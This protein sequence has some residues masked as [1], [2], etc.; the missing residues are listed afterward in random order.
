MRRELD[1]RTHRNGM[2]KDRARA[3][4]R[5]LLAGLVAV[6]M[7][8]MAYAH[9]SVWPR[10]SNAGATERYTVR[11]PTEGKVATT[12]VSLEVPE[13]VRVEELLTPMGWTYEVKREDDRVVA[14]TWNVNV[15]P[16]EF[17]EVGFVALNPRDKS[18][19]VWK[20]RQNFAD[21]SSSDWTNGPNGIYRTAVTSLTPAPAR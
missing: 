3:T 11:V 19:L 20:L 21:G 6:L 5:M 16:G 13:G 10:Q 1:V 12:L 18:Q 4:V 7:P 17:L 2:K 8:A 14:I 9:V 15:K